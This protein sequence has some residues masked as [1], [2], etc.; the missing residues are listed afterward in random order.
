MIFDWEVQDPW[1]TRCVEVRLPHMHQAALTTQS[2]VVVHA[3]KPL[4]ELQRHTLAHNT[5]GVH[6]VDDALSPRVEQ[7]ADQF[8]H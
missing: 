8:T 1:V 2:I 7:V 4:F 6:R 3:R 5:T